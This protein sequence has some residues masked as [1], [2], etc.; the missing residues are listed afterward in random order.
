MGEPLGSPK[1]SDPMTMPFRRLFALGLVVAGC[2]GFVTDE[3]TGLS[4]LTGVDGGAVGD[5]G[6]VVVDTPDAAVAADG[7]VF[8]AGTPPVIDAGPELISLFVANGHQGRTI[9]SCDDGKTWVANQSDNPAFV[10]WGPNNT[11]NPDGGSNDCDH[12]ENSGH[13]VE[14]SNGWFVASYGHGAPG[15]VR[16]SRDG[17]NWVRSL[18]GSNFDALVVGAGGTML[19][20]NRSPSWSRDDGLTWQ[21]GPDAEFV[22]SNGDPIWNVRAATFGNGEFAMFAA[23]S[24]HEVR[25]TVDG[26]QAWVHA[27]FPDVCGAAYTVGFGS[28]G[29]R[30]LYVDQA[31][32]C[33]STDGMHFTAHALPA[34][35]ES[36]PM[37]SGTEFLVWGNRGDPT[38]ERIVMRSADGVTWTTTALATRTALPDGGFQLGGAPVVGAVGHNAN[39]TF[40]MVNGGWEAWYD[41]QQFYR[42][43]DGIT[44]DVLPH[45]AFVG[46]H[47]IGRIVSGR[48]ER[49]A[50]CK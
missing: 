11:G 41:R 38:Y 33:V 4:G 43:T 19:A 17:V 10:C 46:S 9:I 25:V 30:M 27:D 37:W 15:S 7:S 22:N 20:A 35:A 42:S 14:F 31:T 49:P 36:G 40:A 28:G 18:E 34:G 23:D 13:G 45:T 3:L 26:G 39:G 2:Q 5:S 21:R 24:T 48:V 6:T 32:A 16:R 8:D 29:G 1:A 12:T 44:W 47:P 50:I